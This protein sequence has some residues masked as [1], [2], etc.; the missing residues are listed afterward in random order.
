MSDRRKIMCATEATLLGRLSLEW[1]RLS[2]SCWCVSFATQI[3]LPV[4]PEA[5]VWWSFFVHSTLC[6][7]S[8]TK[9]TFTVSSQ[10]I[11][12][13][14][15]W[16]KNLLIKWPDAWPSQ[17]EM[18]MPDADCMAMM[19][20]FCLLHLSGERRWML[21]G[22]KQGRRKK[23]IWSTVSNNSLCLER[24]VKIAFHLKERDKNVTACFNSCEY[25]HVT[26]A[27]ETR[28]SFRMWWR[29]N[30]QHITREKMKKG[31]SM[32]MDTMP[33]SS[34]FSGWKWRRDYCFSRELKWWVSIH[35]QEY[36]HCVYL[37][38][39]DGKYLRYSLLFI[40]R[41]LYLIYGL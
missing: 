12:S 30:R 36:I 41:L 18:C 14:R 22:T 38:I 17:S 28:V 23:I 40:G 35:W 5:S 7:P 15:G 39:N 2:F 21:E 1:C 26:V 16:K 13:V 11:L 6:P 37:R 8:T 20:F 31:A 9:F 27:L 34:L 33:S 32:K 4:W 24:V 29:I 19:M 25:F 10:Q 3:C